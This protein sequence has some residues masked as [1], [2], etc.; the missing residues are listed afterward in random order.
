MRLSHP[1][2]FRQKYI[3]ALKKK[4]KE[5]LEKKIFKDDGFPGEMGRWKGVSNRFC[6]TDFTVSVS[7]SRC[8]PAFYF[9]LRS[10]AGSLMLEVYTV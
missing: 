6:A 2:L 4:L 7:A 5:T 1:F 8:S 3:F 9:L 10:K